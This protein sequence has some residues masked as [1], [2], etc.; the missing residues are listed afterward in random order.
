[1][2]RSETALYEAGVRVAPNNAKLHHNYAYNT[3]GDKKEFH[4]REALR[5]YPPYISAYIN[6]GVHLAHNGRAAEAVTVYK[7]ALAMHQKHP[8]YSTDVGVI[9]RNLAQSYIRLEQNALALEQYQ[10]CLKIQPNNQ[11][12]T[13]WVAY[14]QQ[15][16]P[17]KPKSKSKSKSEKKSKDVKEASF[18]DVPHV[19]DVEYSG[20]RKEHPKSFVM[21]YAPWCSHCN[22]MKQD[23]ARVWQQSPGMRKHTFWFYPRLLTLTCPYHVP[24]VEWCFAR[25][26]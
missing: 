13:E 20:F 21:F 18:D 8:L 10:K 12:C 14:L 26:A 5:L 3:D 11:H 4:L 23:F 16:S 9:Y 19:Q 22:D 24:V 1:M 17:S 6:L 7:E 2:W 25:I 15:Q